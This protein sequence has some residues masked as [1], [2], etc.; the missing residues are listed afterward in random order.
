MFFFF[1]LSKISWLQIAAHEAP[2]LL[3]LFTLP[4]TKSQ[5]EKEHEENEKR[6]MQKKQAKEDN[7]ADNKYINGPKN[8]L[9]Y[10]QIL[11]TEYKK[12]LESILGRN[13]IKLN[14]T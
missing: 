2:H 14:D 10:I 7:S 8:V 11:N 4:L 5:N 9:Q 12:K 1:F 6:S 13:D 3:P